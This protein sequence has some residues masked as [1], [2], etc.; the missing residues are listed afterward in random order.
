[1]PREDALTMLAARAKSPWWSV[2][3]LGAFVLVLFDVA[4]P[5]ALEWWADGNARSAPHLDTAQA[6]SAAFQNVVA[7]H[8]I[9]PL[10]IIG[11]LAALVCGAIA[12]ARFVAQRRDRR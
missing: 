9:L 10:R 12:G 3:L 8:A 11:A 5:L 2:A 7:L 1:V 6:M 4:V